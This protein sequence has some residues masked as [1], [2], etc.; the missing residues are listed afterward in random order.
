[1]ECK[2]T[3]RAAVPLRH[4]SR[5]RAQQGA[6][7]MGPEGFQVPLRRTGTRSSASCAAG[8][9]ASRPP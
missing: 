7:C 8:Y 5:R 2:S 6:S 9:Q 3:P 1:M 4:I